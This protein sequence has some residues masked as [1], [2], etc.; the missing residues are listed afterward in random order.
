MSTNPQDP[1]QDDQAPDHVLHS[2]VVEAATDQKRWDEA[3][4][5]FFPRSMRGRVP[6]VWILL[7]EKTNRMVAEG[8]LLTVAFLTLFS[9]I[10]GAPHRAEWISLITAVL[11]PIGF[12][13]WYVLFPLNPYQTFFF[14]KQGLQNLDQRDP[15]AEVLTKT[16][17]SPAAGQFLWRRTQVFWVIFVVPM[18][19]AILILH[20]IPALAANASWLVRIPVFCAVLYAAIRIETMGWALQVIRNSE[21]AQ[22][23]D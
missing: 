21:Q 11:A 17:S 2:P 22:S 23:T 18:L 10:I 8:T 20:R 1:S 7:L 13:V 4:F 16:F 19:I 3:R 14:A 6:D 15:A 12:T 5:R 9:T